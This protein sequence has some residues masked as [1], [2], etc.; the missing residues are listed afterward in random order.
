MFED[1]VN[2][3]D[4][5]Q[6]FDDAYKLARLDFAYQ[7][8]QMGVD[9]AYNAEVS[10]VF[11][12]QNDCASEHGCTLKVESGGN[13]E[14]GNNWQQWNAAATIEWWT[15]SNHYVKF[16]FAQP[17]GRYADLQLKGVEIGDDESLVFYEEIRDLCWQAGRTVDITE[18]PD[19]PDSAH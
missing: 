7:A 11:H 12:H 16:H 9:A 6:P 13:L 8:A 18:R 19:R 15:S 3:S 4:L 14:W 2:V 17:G 10:L 5:F 1:H